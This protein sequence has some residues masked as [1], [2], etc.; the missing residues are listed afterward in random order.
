MHHWFKSYCNVAEWM[1][2]VCL[3][4]C[5]EKGLCRQP[6]QQ[7]HSDVLAGV[8]IPNILVN[9]GIKLGYQNTKENV[10]LTLQ[11]SVTVHYTM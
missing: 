7:F 11:H 8:I 10:L 1:N 6:V 4:S 3:W 2:F 9:L 5:I